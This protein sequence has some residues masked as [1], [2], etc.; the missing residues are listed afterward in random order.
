MA[1]ELMLYGLPDEVILGPAGPTSVYACRPCRGVVAAVWA[2]FND[3]MLNV[4]VYPDDGRPIATIAYTPTSGRRVRV[5]DHLQALA[6][7]HHLTNELL[8]DM[9]DQHVAH[10]NTEDHN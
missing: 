5:T 8:N 3:I 2:H 7:I 1:H 4:D 6:V 9:P 10:S